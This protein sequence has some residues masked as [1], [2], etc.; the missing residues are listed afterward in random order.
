[1]WTRLYGFSRQGIAKPTTLGCRSS[2]Q[3]TGARP[4]STRAFHTRQH[5][6][7]SQKS[8]F[9]ECESFSF[10]SSKD[11]DTI[12]R[13]GAMGTNPWFGFRCRPRP[14]GWRL[15]SLHPAPAKLGGPPFFSCRGPEDRKI[16]SRNCSA[17]KRRRRVRSVANSTPLFVSELESVC[18]RYVLLFK[19]SR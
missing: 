15:T 14:L 1:M 18:C 8:P 4:A 9:K 10:V 17:H 3:E 5:F 2:W 12:A 13:T 6:Q 7:A 16:K 11:C 19:M